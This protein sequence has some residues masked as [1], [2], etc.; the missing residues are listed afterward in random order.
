MA[1]SATPPVHDTAPGASVPAAPLRPPRTGEILRFAIPLMMGLMTTAI[2]TLVDTVFIGRLGTAPLAAVPLAAMAYVVGWILLVG[3]MRTAIALCA[4]AYGAGRWRDIGPLLAHYHLLAL[5]GL[6]LLLLYVQAWPLASALAGLDPLVDELART[7]LRI[8]AWDVV[9]SLLLIL[10]SAFYQAVGNSRF[11]MMVSVAVVVLN[12][13]LD[14]ALIFGHWGFPALGVAGSAMA[15]VIAQGF[16]AAFIIAASFARPERERFA[17][18]LLIRPRPAMLGEI[19]RIGLPQGIGDCMEIATW[20]GFMLIVGRLGEAPLAASNIGIQV[21]HLLF[22]PGFAFGIAAAS[23][24]G[25]FLGARRPDIARRTARRVLAMGIGYMGLLGI[26]L[27]FFG[28]FIARGFTADPTVI[29]QAGL[30][31]KVMAVYQIFDGAGFITRT[32]LGGAGDTRV[33]MLALVLCALGIMFPAAWGLSR[34]VEPPL[35]G[36][37]L[38]AFAYMA[39]FAAL[40]LLRFAGGR[41]T[42]MRISS[43]ARH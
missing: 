4:R 25:R 38:G 11:P 39:V 24:I 14:Y 23:Y 5:L 9:F 31:F 32:A 42:A 36:A 1:L 12:I 43:D 13:A 3:V 40:M 16:G 35:M 22:L 19:L 15:T 27:W 34:A 30:I 41:W 8:R 10:Y 21:T 26:P 33:P 18:R 2:N 6:P 37:W 20:V 17:L 29:Y 28:E 7:Y